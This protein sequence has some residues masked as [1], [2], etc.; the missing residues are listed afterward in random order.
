MI[1]CRHCK[2]PMP[3][4]TV[5]CPRCGGDQRVAPTKRSNGVTIVCGLLVLSMV[6][7]AVNA[8]LVING[9]T[10]TTAMNQAMAAQGQGQ[11]HGPGPGPIPPPPPGPGG[12]TGGVPP[13]LNMN[14][15]MGIF[16][17]AIWVMFAIKAA[18][19]AL[20]IAFLL[21][22]SNGVRVFVIVWNF[23]GAAVMLIGMATASTFA[24]MTPTTAAKPS[25]G[26]QMVCILIGIIVGTWLIMLGDEFR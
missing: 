21:K 6:I 5:V 18:L 25:S 24:K 15:F 4:T 9:P 22:R 26:V 20:L 11:T 8:Y 12:S 17:G 7:A 16:K 23:L 14:M 2:G 10:F 13:G 1:Y 19:V 3:A